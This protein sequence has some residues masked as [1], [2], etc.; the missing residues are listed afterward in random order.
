M[1]SALSAVPVNCVAVNDPLMFKFP[2]ITVLP[3]ADATVN[4]SVVPDLTAKFASTSTVLLNSDG[5]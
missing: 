3:V 5:L 2:E 4:L 1:L